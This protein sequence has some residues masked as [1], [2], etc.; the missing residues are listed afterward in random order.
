MAELCPLLEGF[1]QA[2]IRVSARAGVSFEALTGEGSASKLMMVWQ[3]S[4]PVEC[5]TEGLNSLLIVGQRPPSVPCY[6]G[7]F[8]WQ[9][10]SSEPEKK[11]I[12]R[13]IWLARWKL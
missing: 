8:M 2:V 3:V 1:S 7:L 11:R 10:V 4:F 5:W 12:N 9:L 6:V 13:D